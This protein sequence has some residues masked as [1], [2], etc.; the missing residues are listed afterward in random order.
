MEYPGTS[1]YVRYLSE[2]SSQNS[3]GTVILITAHT[4]F[5]VSSALVLVKPPVGRLPTS[6]AGA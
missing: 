1:K 5:T 2:H 6:G 3:T 4:Y